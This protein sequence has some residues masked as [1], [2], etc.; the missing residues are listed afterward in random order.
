MQR[1]DQYEDRGFFIQNILAGPLVICDPPHLKNGLYLDPLQPGETVDLSY[2]DQQTLV[3]SIALN[4][5]LRHGYAVTLSADEYYEQNEMESQRRI[6]QSIE[7]QKKMVVT[8][9]ANGI[10]E[11]EQINLSTAGNPHGDYSAEALLAQENNIN[12]PQ[13]WAAEYKKAKDQ[14]LVR[15]PVEFQELVESGRIATQMGNRGRRV[16]IAEM[17]N[18]GAQDQINMTATRATIAMPGSYQVT[19]DGQREEMG[20][21]YTQRRQL[22]NFN[23]TGNMVGAGDIGVEDSPTPAYSGHPGM[24]KNAYAQNNAYTEDFV[25]DIDLEQEEAEYDRNY[26]AQNNQIA[27]RLAPRSPYLGATANRPTARR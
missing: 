13:V 27:E 26:V 25:E 23:A 6:A 14:G 24:Q 9:A 22:T 7:M 21:V 20:G 1:T 5:A 10:F 19:N 16:S 11:A 12:S 4:N 2:Y 17:R 18:E 3:R 8:E 15:S